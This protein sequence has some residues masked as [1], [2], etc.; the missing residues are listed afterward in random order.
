MYP[1]FFVKKLF[2]LL[3]WLST[4]SGLVLVA[5][6]LLINF[7]IPDIERSGEAFGL[8]LEWLI[9]GYVIVAFVLPLV[10]LLIRKEITKTHVC[11]CVAHILV[12]GFFLKILL[13]A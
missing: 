3:L 10:A 13:R 4:L 11:L 5:I 12:G 9:P 1:V 2:R 8:T 7:I 6:I